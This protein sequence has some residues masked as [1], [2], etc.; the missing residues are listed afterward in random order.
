M[1]IVNKL[2]SQGLITPPSFLKDNIH[3]ECMMGSIA[4]GCSNDNS[5]IDLYGFCIPPKD[6]IFPH[7]AG[8]IQDFG[9]KPPRF[10][11]YQQHHIKDLLT[12]KEY[13]ISMFSIIKYFQLVMENNPN[14]IDSLFVPRRCI[15]HSTQL[16][17]RV[18]EKRKIFLHK[19][20]W[21]KFKGY[22]YSQ[23]QK[24]KNKNI[25]K[26]VE[27]CDKLEINYYILMEDFLILYD[28]TLSEIDSL[29]FRSLHSKVHQSGNIS[30]RI[31]T[32]IKFGYDVKFAYHIVRLLNEVEQI[33][34]EGDLDLE[35][36]REQL[37]SIR[38]GD[39]TLEEIDL[40]FQKKELELETLYTNSTLQYS[41]NEEDIKTLLLECL[42]THYG[43][44][45]KV[46]S[47]PDKLWKAFQNIRDITD[48]VFSKKS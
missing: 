24:C 18:R 8:Y 40:Y 41:P 26:Y 28:K 29:R 20:S 43:S 4:Y 3:Y 11:Q 23:L 35:R 9:T 48:E 36:N 7:T 39:W 16:F 44:L 10:D 12:E 6:I 13:D 5:D 19:G 32:I 30:K 14:M 37:K 15:L 31:D 47:Q 22:A 45:D 38:R 1:S 21:Y 33:L 25:L 17:E 34:T 42:E 27:L 2:I 46:I